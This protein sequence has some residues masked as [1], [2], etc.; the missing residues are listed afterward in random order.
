MYGYEIKDG[1]AIIEEKEALVIRMIFENYLSGMSLTAAAKNAG[2]EMVH[3]TV[4]A[5]IRRKH[6]IG[7]GYYPQIVEKDIFA[8]ANG[9]LLR[10]ASKHFSGMIRKKVPV[11]KDFIMNTP[12]KQYE[13]PIKQ[14]EYL[15]SLIEVKK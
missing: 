11:F 14:A 13:D 9:E 2:V 3:G 10:R 1:K 5:I 8:R 4:R 6:Y 7:D 12:A 15:Y